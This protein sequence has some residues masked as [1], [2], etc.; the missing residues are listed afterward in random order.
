[1]R[2]LSGFAVVALLSF[3]L[4]GCV[5]L[6]PPIVPPP[7]DTGD[8]VNQAPVALAGADGSVLSGETVRLDGSSSSDA[9]RDRLTFFWTQLSGQPRVDLSGSNS[10]VARFVAPTV[11]ED[12]QYVFRLT[13]S[14]GT[15]TATDDVIITV[16][17]TAQRP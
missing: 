11:F 12:R 1:M 14:D 13:I 10:A 7:D 17:P 5:D 6:L 9:D 16:M 8:A 2:S 15:T 3:G 4:G